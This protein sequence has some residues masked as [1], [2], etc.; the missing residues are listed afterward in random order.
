MLFQ[1]VSNKHIFIDNEIRLLASSSNLTHTW[2]YQK[3]LENLPI[4]YAQIYCEG[5]TL[6]EAFLKITGVE[7]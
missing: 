5:K 4:E 6:E 3:N 2:S 7:N 1:T